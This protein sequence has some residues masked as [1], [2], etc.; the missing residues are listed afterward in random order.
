MLYWKDIP[1]HSLLAVSGGADSTA[2]LY[3]AV[4]RN[5]PV[6]I[7]HVRHGDREQQYVA[8]DFVKQLAVNSGYR[9]LLRVISDPGFGGAGYEAKCRKARYQLLA[10][11]AVESDS[12]ALITAHTRDDVAESVAIAIHRK[13]GLAAL[14]GI[15]ER[16]KLMLPDRRKI[17]VIR[18]LLDLRRDELRE[19]LLDQGY[20]WIED[21]TNSDPAYGLRNRIRDEWRQWAPQRRDAEIDRLLSIAKDAK[22]RLEVAGTVVERIWNEAVTA[23]ENAMEVFTSFLE[24]GTDDIVQVMLVRIARSFGLE[25]GGFPGGHRRQFTD[26]VRNRRWG[27]SGW[28]GAGLRY[29]VTR[30]TCRFWRTSTEIVP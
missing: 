9:Y 10:E 14:A 5:L 4:E 17:D 30:R 11:M 15:P 23:Q 3:L 20:L 13:Q 12:P 6:A 2:L 25:A 27:A 16:R 21:E 18:P 24:Q 29:R 7:G 19:W 1:D 26:I 28:L 8:A 22:Q